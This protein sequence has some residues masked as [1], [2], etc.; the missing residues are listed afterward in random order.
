MKENAEK[1]A[2]LKKCREEYLAKMD[3]CEVVIF[4]WKSGGR[5]GIGNPE[6]KKKILQFCA[7]EAQRQ[8]DMLEGK[9]P[10][11]FHVALLFGEYAVQ[12]YEN[13]GVDGLNDWLKGEEF[14]DIDI[15]ERHFDSKEL[16]QAYLDGINEFAGDERTPGDWC[17]MDYDDLNKLK[18]E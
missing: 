8:I 4:Q 14:P 17:V 13:G 7:D 16:M 3:D 18:Y 6:M 11:K 15:R 2:N 10:E 1:I 12:E 5:G 9:E